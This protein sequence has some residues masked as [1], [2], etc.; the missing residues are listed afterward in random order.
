M[1]E[2]FPHTERD[3]VLQLFFLA[4]TM[5]AIREWHDLF[6]VLKRMCFSA[7]LS[8]RIEGKINS[9][10]DKQKLRVH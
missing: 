7:R 1:A 6:K 9:L 2:N 10:P 5:Q 8:F 3:T 4:E